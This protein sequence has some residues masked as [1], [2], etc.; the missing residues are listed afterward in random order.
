MFKKAWWFGL[1]L[2]VSPS[3]QAMDDLILPLQQIIPLAGVENI[4]WKVGDWTEYRLSMSFLKGKLLKKCTQNEGNSVWLETKMEIP[5]GNQLI[6][7]QIRKSDGKILKLIVNGR[8]QEIK[9]P[10][11]TIISQE[12]ETVT[13]PAGTFQTIHLL[14]R[15]EE[16]RDTNVW[17]NPRDV[18]LE[19]MVKTLTEQQFGTVSLE[20]TRFGQGA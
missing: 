10:K 9:S 3:L 1:F 16:N 12:A 7:A 4:D 2:L 17:I 19:G 8:E 15:D 14:L 5:L 11:Y 6:L 20:L 18:V 13:V